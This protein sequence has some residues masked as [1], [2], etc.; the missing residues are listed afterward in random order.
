M[1]PDVPARTDSAGAKGA[2]E[3]SRSVGELLVLDRRTSIVNCNPVRA[4]RLPG[5]ESRCGVEGWARV[6]S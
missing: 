6:A 2:G 1:E 5:A 4:L 3:S